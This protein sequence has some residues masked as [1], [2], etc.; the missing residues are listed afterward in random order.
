MN[1]VI[2]SKVAGLFLIGLLSASAQA[3]DA[4]KA[5]PSA[6]HHKVVFQVSENDPKKWAL[7]LNNVQNVQKDL[8]K[9]DTDIEI[10]AYGPGLDMLKSESVVGER[11]KQ[12]LAA[13]VKVSACENTMRAQHVTKEDLLPNVGF[14]PS[15]VVE[16]ISKQEHGYAYVRP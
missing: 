9:E 15:G 3:A 2:T 7:A 1:R 8:G 13:G 11:I 16:I 14:V 4:A 12:T 10:V 6:P 5:A